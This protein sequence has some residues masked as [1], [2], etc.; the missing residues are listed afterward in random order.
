MSTDEKPE[1]KTAKQIERAVIDDALKDK[2]ARL[3]D[4]GNSALQ[5]IATVTKS[6][7]VNLVL[8][9]HAD[10]LSGAEIERLKVTHLDQVKYAFWVANKLKTARAAGESLSLQDVLAMSSPAINGPARAPKLPRKKKD[11]SDHTTEPAPTQV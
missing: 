10:E 1:K 6:D 2:L 5:G 7:I 8:E 11:K 3:V 9:G 4:Q